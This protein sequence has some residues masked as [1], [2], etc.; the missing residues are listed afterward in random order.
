[1]EKSLESVEKECLSSKYSEAIGVLAVFHCQDEE[2]GHVAMDNVDN[3]AVVSDAETVAT[4]Q[5]VM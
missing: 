1:M 5:A 4:K 2:N 3:D